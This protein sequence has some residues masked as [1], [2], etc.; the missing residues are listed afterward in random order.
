M[1]ATA[2]EQSDEGLSQQDGKGPVVAGLGEIGSWNLYQDEDVFTDELEHGAVLAA[3]N[4]YQL[5]VECG[6]NGF[7]VRLDVSTF[8]IGGWGGERSWE[9]FAIRVG[10]GPI[11]AL[12][13][14]IASDEEW[15]GDDNDEWLVSPAPVE[16]A[17]VLIASDGAELLVRH[18]DDEET[19][20]LDLSGAANALPP[21]LGACEV[22]GFEGQPEVGQVAAAAEQVAIDN[23]PG[24]LE[25]I[26]ELA[27]LEDPESSEELLVSCAEYADCAAGPTQ[28]WIDTQGGM[29]VQEFGLGLLGNT[30][31]EW[32]FEYA[33]SILEEAVSCSVSPG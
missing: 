28:D 15:V 20:T 14:Y 11:Q 8:F 30:D 12:E 19:G 18:G 10:G 4:G 7:S 21:V 3:D 17:G 24:S 1:V 9:E 22:E 5:E 16:F 13:W 27:C 26:L 23:L 6:R 33:F 32:I 31:P 29:T 25:G 2:V